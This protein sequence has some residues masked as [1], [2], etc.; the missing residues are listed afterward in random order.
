MALSDSETENDKLLKPA[1]AEDNSLTTNLHAH[2][3]EAA[4]LSLNAN[5]ESNNLHTPQ[6]KDADK[7]NNGTKFS[8]HIDAS[9]EEQSCLVIHANKGTDNL[10]SFT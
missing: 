5:D 8:S 10:F 6:L 7:R 2:K 1:N 3:S 4:V 9:G